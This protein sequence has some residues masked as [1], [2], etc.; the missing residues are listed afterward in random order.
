MKG[1][2]RA[3]YIGTRRPAMSELGCWYIEGTTHRDRRQ[4][5]SF[6]GIQHLNDGAY[7]RRANVQYGGKQRVGSR[8]DLLA[9][10]KRCSTVP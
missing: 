9:T 1:D 6:S 3:T 7:V 5:S 4:T 2:L 10:P 8:D